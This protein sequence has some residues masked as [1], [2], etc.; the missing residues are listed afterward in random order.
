[1]TMVTWV[2]LGE[3][4]GKTSAT[5]AVFRDQ[6]GERRAYKAD[7]STR[8]VVGGL[9][10]VTLG[11][12]EALI[13]TPVWTGDLAD[14]AD[15]IKMDDR[16]RRTERERAAMIRKARTE[17]PCQDL[18]DLAAEQARNL[19]MGGR[20]QLADDLAYVIFRSRR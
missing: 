10:N 5:V 7:K 16:R 6:A 12:D 8:S 13:G 1:M 3:F 14:D 15:S 2:Y 17:H 18:L 20:Q 9:H 11:E 4:P 19:S